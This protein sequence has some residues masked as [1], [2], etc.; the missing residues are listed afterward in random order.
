ML[1][2]IHSFFLFC[3]HYSLFLPSRIRRG[4]SFGLFPCFVGESLQK[5]HISP[6]SS[7]YSIE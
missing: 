2:S 4:F 7:M 5:L 3:F 1:H 6:T